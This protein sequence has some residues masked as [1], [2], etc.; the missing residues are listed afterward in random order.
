MADWSE[1]RYD[2]HDGDGESDDGKEADTDYT[3]VLNHTDLPIWR[4]IALMI[5][6]APTVMRPRKQEC[7]FDGLVPS[8]LDQENGNQATLASGAGNDCE[9]S[10]LSWCDNS[11]GE[12]SC[13][14]QV[15]ASL[16]NGLRHLSLH[17]R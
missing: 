15:E 3:D 16:S 9:N 1:D 17:D 10:R 5:V 14:G 12:A 8:V 6:H 2:A 11:M 13:A 4:E 7:P